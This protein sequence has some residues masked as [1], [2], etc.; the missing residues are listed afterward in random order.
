MLKHG[1][2]R[3]LRDSE[4]EIEEEAE[5]L[6]RMFESALKRRRRGSV[7]RLT[8]DVQMD[9]ELRDFVV[10]ELDVSAEDVFALGGVIGL[11]D[12]DQLIVDDRQDLV[13]TPMSPRFPE[14]IRDFGGD[15]FAACA[16]RTSS[17]IIPTRASTSSSNSSVRQP[18]TRRSSPSSRPSIAPA[19]TRRWSAP[20]IEAAEAGKSVTA[21]VELKARFDEE[22]NIRWARNMERAGVQVVYGFIRLK[23]HAKVAL[24]V[25]REGKSYRTYCH[26]G[27]GNY[28]P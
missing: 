20:L 15:C 27:T 13:F 8:V 22:R 11:S 12:A 10:D 17:S 9:Q 19:R 4:V 5:D 16:T 21:L 1:Y 6:V 26:F 25:R 7:I 14:R 3:V 18:R 24:V 23:T 2:F 28:H